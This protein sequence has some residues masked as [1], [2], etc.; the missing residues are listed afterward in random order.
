M[1][2]VLKYFEDR[3][4][5]LVLAC[6]FTLSFAMSLVAYAEE[7]VKIGDAV[8]GLIDAIKVGGAGVILAAVVQILK[9]DFAGGLLSKV[10]AKYLP[11]ITAAVAVLG[12]V[13]HG[14]VATPERQIWLV[15]LEGVLIALTS[16]GVFDLF[17]AKK[18]A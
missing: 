3:S 2:N 5:A 4:F 6:L 1:K 9:S 16:N 10:N 14:L 18:A 7:P 8:I 15:I 12:N 13:A 17:K 11:W